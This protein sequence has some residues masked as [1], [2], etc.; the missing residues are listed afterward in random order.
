M[1]SRKQTKQAL[2]DSYRSRGLSE[3]ES[4]CRGMRFE[5]LVVYIIDWRIGWAPDEK[6]WL[7]SEKT[8][9]TQAVNRGGE[10]S[11]HEKEKKTPD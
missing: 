8:P 7:R 1:A 4:V 9:K 5:A 3:T 10:E 6:V 11:R 2:I